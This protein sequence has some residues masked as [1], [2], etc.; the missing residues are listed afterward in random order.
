MLCY[1]VAALH[2]FIEGPPFTLQRLSE[3]IMLLLECQV[4]LGFINSLLVPFRRRPLNC[5]IIERD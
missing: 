3:V 1:S 5:L 4:S 2:S